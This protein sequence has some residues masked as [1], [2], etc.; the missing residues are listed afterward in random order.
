[1]SKAYPHLQ[2]DVGHLPLMVAEL[3]KRELISYNSRLN[4]S[5]IIR[6]DTSNLIR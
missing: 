3:K 4:L 1:M 2:L 5:F 6:A